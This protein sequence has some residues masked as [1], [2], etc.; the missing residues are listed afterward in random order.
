L[1]VYIGLSNDL[2]LTILGARTHAAPDDLT[3]TRGALIGAR[4]LLTFGVVAIV[5]P[6]LILFPLGP[7]GRLV[8]LVLTV[9]YAV[10]AINIRWVA[11]AQE[12][13][14][15]I[16]VAEVVGSFVQLL[17]VVLFVHGPEDVGSAAVA[18]VAMPVAST[19]ILLFQRDLIRRIPVRVDRE[20]LRLIRR[21]APL[22]VALFATALYYSADS[23]LL[24]VFRGSAEVGYYA[25]AYRVVLAC[26]IVPVVAHSVLLPIIA[27]L[28]RTHELTLVETLQGASRGLVW[29]AL[30]IAVGTTLTAATV[31]SLVFGSTYAPSA[32]ALTLLIWSVVTVSTNVPFAV[33]MLARSQDRMYMAVTVLGA[34]IN[35]VSNL[36]AIPALGMV[37]AAATTLISEVSVLGAILWYTRDMS[38]TIVARSFAWALPPTVIMAVA[39][40]PFRD[41]VGAIGIG[42]VVY[43]IAS[44][45]TRALPTTSVRR[46][47][48]DVFGS[49]PAERED[50]AR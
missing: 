43:I 48:A 38:A 26:L 39:V 30:P 36:V 27:R 9:G 45:L 15:P 28:Q 2:G 18:T 14:V 22:G 6:A 16:A 19:V 32:P 25:A 10:S 11:Q 44:V 8:A 24:G 50:G 21:A 31:V 3:R 29:I 40:Y 41:E 7:E 49:V 42:L 33:L 5:L 13:F 20:S 46:L 12:R 23:V 17:T 1:F 37:G 35:L 34:I 47:V 4:L